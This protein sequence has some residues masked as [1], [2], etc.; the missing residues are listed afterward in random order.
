VNLI[1]KEL[2][3]FPVQQWR[4]ILAEMLMQDGG[5]DITEATRR[6]RDRIDGILSRTTFIVQ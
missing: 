5:E 3:N 2:W 6:I 1:E 4:P